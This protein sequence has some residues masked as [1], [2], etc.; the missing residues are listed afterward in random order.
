MTDIQPKKRGRPR[1][2]RPS[3][4]ETPATQVSPVAETSE[5]PIRTLAR[6]IEAE[7]PGPI[8]EPDTFY[9]ARALVEE[10]DPMTGDVIA[11][12]DDPGDEVEL[13]A[14][15]GAGNDYVIVEEWGEDGTESHGRV[16][17]SIFNA[18]VVDGDLSN[19]LATAERPLPASFDH[20]HDGHPGGSLPRAHLTDLQVVAYTRDVMDA[21]MGQHEVKRADAWNRVWTMR[22]EIVRNH[23]NI[24]VR[25]ARGPMVA[26][27]LIPASQMSNERAE[28]AIRAVDAET[29]R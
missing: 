10:L 15:E 12:Y 2:I 14:L 27:R 18:A 8:G 17:A 6:E 24:L 23:D 28:E 25:C 5:N 7:A 11:V 9:A 20:D 16:S 1:K 22:H 21:Y 19:V 29:E 3:E 4:A 26:E 13:P